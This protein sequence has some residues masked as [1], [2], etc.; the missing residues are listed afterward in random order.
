MFKTKKNKKSIGTRDWPIAKSSE[1]MVPIEG[2]SVN[3]YDE[4]SFFDELIRSLRKAKYFIYMVF[5]TIENRGISVK[6]LNVLKEMAS[7]GVEIKLMIDWMGCNIINV[8]KQDGRTRRMSLN[9]DFLNQYRSENFEIVYYNR[10]PKIFP[11]NH[12]KMVIIDCKVAFVGGMNLVDGYITGIEGRRGHAYYTDKQLQ[13]LGPIVPKLCQIFAAI[14]EETTHKRLQINLANVQKAGDISLSVITTCGHRFRP[15]FE[16]IMVKLIDSAQKEILI[17][18]PYVVLLP[19]VK[20]ALKHAIRNRHVKVIFLLGLE[21]DMSPL[22]EAI[23][24]LFAS[25]AKR[26]GAKVVKNP[27]YFHH[28]KCIIIDETKLLTGSHNMDLISCLLQHEI[29]IITDNKNIIDIFLSYAR[30]CMGE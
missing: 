7:K 28:D 18:S 21:S 17:R 10:W 2:N 5:F 27:G 11:R 3:V 29:S 8:E 4:Q 16:D 15:Y 20:R 22:F 13:L 19:R 14:W 12:Q 6:V 30:S 23:L 1:W 25:S 26:I 9:E 24:S